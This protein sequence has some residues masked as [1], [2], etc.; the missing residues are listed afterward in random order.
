MQIKVGNIEYNLPDEGGMAAAILKLINT[1]E[2]RVLTIRKCGVK[3]EEYIL[4]HLVRMY[5][6]RW[7]LPVIEIEHS[8]CLDVSLVP[9]MQKRFWL[10]MFGRSVDDL[11]DRD[12]AFFSVSDSILLTAIYSSLLNFQPSTAEGNDLLKRTAKSLSP[13]QD[14]L[15]AASLTMELICQDVCHRVAYFLSSPS[16]G[17]RAAKLVQSYIGVLLGRCDL[18]DCLADGATGLQSTAISRSLHQ[19]VADP[20]GKIHLN[21]QLLEWY[22]STEKMIRQEADFLMINLEKF[23]ANYAASV[24]KDTFRQSPFNWMPAINHPR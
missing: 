9:E 19:S 21:S 7:V 16:V 8:G 10:C 13:W 17:D 14:E 18:D 11:H 4:I 22:L 2:Q 12:S 1:E 23:G 5:I 6:L 24:V 3:A 20:E 15:T